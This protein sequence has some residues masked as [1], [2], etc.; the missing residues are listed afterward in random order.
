MT[1]LPTLC[2]ILALAAAPPALAHPRLVA[3]SPARSAVIK[4]AP[5][6]IRVSFSDILQA[7]AS[8]LRLKDA[9][10]RPVR[11]GKT[12][13]DP[14]DGRTLILPLPHRLAPGKYT[15]EWDVVSKDHASVPG[16]YR[17]QIR[18]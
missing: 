10:G 18:P 9:A 1:R 4:T 3:T 8:I 17:F 7:D 14:R 12:A 6:Q 11:T 5:R 15:V 16:R 2:L 13:G